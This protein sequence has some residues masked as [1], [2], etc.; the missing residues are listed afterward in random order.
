M[1]CSV[2]SIAP[3]IDIN[4]VTLESP[5]GDNPE[6][7]VIITLDTSVVEEITGR[8]AA[9]WFEES[10]YSEFLRIR[11][12]YSFNSGLSAGLDYAK[13]RFNQYMNLSKPINTQDGELNVN[14]FIFLTYI[15][16]ADEGQ[17]L[18][19]SYLSEVPQEWITMVDGEQV[20]RPIVLQNEEFLANPENSP[21]YSRTNI[22]A[23]EESSRVNGTQ[24]GV[25]KANAWRGL[26]YQDFSLSDMVEKS[27]LPGN[28]T[29]YN[30]QTENGENGI[31]KE[32]VFL[33]QLQIKTNDLGRNTTDGN[34]NH[35]S[36]YC[37]LYLDVEEFYRSLS[38]D[39]PED[40]I[41]EAL[42]TGMGEIS[43]ATVIGDYLEYTPINI[44]EI[45]DESGTKKYVTDN[46]GQGRYANWGGRSFTQ[47]LSP[48][49]VQSPMFVSAPEVS[50][51]EDLRM[52]GQMDPDPIQYRIFD[53]VYNSL[54]GSSLASPV[55][56]MIKDEN[57]FS[58]IYLTKNEDEMV[59]YL[60]FCDQQ[61]LLANSSPLPYLYMNDVTFNE[62]TSGFITIPYPYNADRILRVPIGV[63]PAGILETTA[64]RRRTS[65]T[66]T[67]QD[68]QLPSFKNTKRIR[69]TDQFVEERVNISKTN[70]SFPSSLSE[71]GNKK[72]A[73][74]EG[75][76]M[77][78]DVP[79]N[80]IARYQYGVKI[81]FHDA[82]L[83]YMKK[84]LDI[85]SEA[86]QTTREI[87]NY[88][89]TSPPT[90]YSNPNWSQRQDPRI[91]NGLYDYNTGRIR[92]DLSTVI[93][94]TVTRLSPDGDVFPGLRPGALLE[95]DRSLHD[96]LSQQIEIYV[97]MLEK[98]K[99]DTSPEFIRFVL[100]NM[101]ESQAAAKILE[102]AD[103]I[104][105]FVS[106]LDSVVSSIFPKSNYDK[107]QSKIKP[108]IGRVPTL[109]SK[110]LL[111]EK[112]HYFRNLISVG[113][114]DK[115]GYSYFSH[116]SADRGD[117][118][119]IQHN[120]KRMSAQ[121]FTFRAQDEVLKCF[122]ATNGD[123][124]V[125]NR[126]DGA[127][128][129]LGAPFKTSAYRYLTPGT[130]KRPGKPDILQMTS[131][132]LRQNDMA[133]VT[134]G[135][136]SYADLFLDLVKHKHTSKFFNKESDTLQN[137]NYA[138]P[139]NNLQNQ[140]FD[141]VDDLL[142]K[143]YGSSLKAG[144]DILVQDFSVPSERRG[145]PTGLTTSG[146]PGRRG[147]ISFGG[148]A[149]YASILGG[150]SRVNPA[151]VTG[152]D[153]IENRHREQA[154][155]LRQELS[156]RASVTSNPP[157][158]LSFA[159]MGEMEL[160]NSIGSNYESIMF[161]SISNMG[162]HL[163]GD[164]PADV[165]FEIQSGILQTFPNHLKALMI[166]GSTV[167]G[168]SIGGGFSFDAKRFVLRD[169]ETSEEA[170]ENISYQASGLSNPPYGVVKDPM[171]VYEKFMSIWMN[172]K[173]LAVVEYLDGFGDLVFDE[174]ET[175]NIDRAYTQ[176]KLAFPEW[177]KI[178]NN[179]MQRLLT[180]EGG[181]IGELF[182][183]LRFISNGDL[184]DE[185]RMAASQLA[186][187]EGNVLEISEQISRIR[188]SDIFGSQ[189]I[190]NLPIYDE[191]FFIQGVSE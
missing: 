180:G 54:Q 1:V 109:G 127:F 65:F 84:A 131:A 142:V 186:E 99:I 161:N 125:G 4:K 16:M 29:G 129:S 48:F 28:R 110:L 171:K 139:P 130:I 191:Y 5:R 122:K 120:I 15:R 53:K 59:N 18:S 152:S 133:S 189:E 66:Q 52:L 150:S 185:A 8:A 103:T 63:P 11:T 76:D 95:S 13:Q 32:R 174:E 75:H 61:S 118:T 153:A 184:V 117:N 108:L 42:S 128:A 176:E 151:A 158:K 105:M 114:N 56:D 123:S 169:L 2:N 74:Y 23:I 92:L 17:L 119:R 60:F 85:L 30:T 41:Y 141:S 80:E 111:Y 107:Q 33:K 10:G 37:Y 116:P 166:V 93:Y 40:T 14:D 38:V 168:S 179:I 83:S 163:V 46:I 165:L 178:D 94:D 177:K 149:M 49:I 22:G 7:E 55:A 47:V 145:M 112:E 140:V 79:S 70:I 167:E 159:I 132:G 164:D 3:Q 19:N 39:L 82:S 69:P 90:N 27:D 155:E 104:G 51:L 121:A 77:M 87:Y 162:R 78:D 135:M 67:T 81:T 126:M 170:D 86:E 101:I 20:V 181:N 188:E 89:I 44:E 88:I 43:S 9:R 134:L 183:R 58:E 136:N 157:L 45:T 115:F 156:D 6:N 148:E 96:V 34:I 124:L 137:V 50:I 26:Y 36:I 72:I 143:N 31:L 144:R 64:K 172:Y 35:L 147:S 24:G 160:D 68:N 73:V 21:F 62:L 91:R 173:Q 71:T 146:R 106:S 98:F 154:N 138:D 175:P 102:V 25:M 97:S 100:H 190:F 12:V 57:S 113:V 182:C 187:G